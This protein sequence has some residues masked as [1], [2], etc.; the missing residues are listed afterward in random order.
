MSQALGPL[1][2]R[3][4]EQSG[5]VERQRRE[6]LFF[7]QQFPKGDCNVTIV[8]AS[9][10]FGTVRSSAQSK[11]QRLR[12]HH[13]EV[14]GAECACREQCCSECRA[15]CHE[16]IMM[17]RCRPLQGMRWPRRS[18]WNERADPLAGMLCVAWNSLGWLLVHWDV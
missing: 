14:D 5:C 16:G 1:R 17:G 13:V 7:T 8:V 18:A 3:G 9:T 12:G 10:E 6:P 2:R 11:G 15:R 4:N